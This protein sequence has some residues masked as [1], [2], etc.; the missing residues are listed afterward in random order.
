MLLGSA[1]DHMTLLRMLSGMS[2]GVETLTATPGRA[3]SDLPVV[4]LAPALQEVHT[5][6]RP[7]ARTSTY[8]LHRG[9]VRHCNTPC[10]RELQLRRG[11]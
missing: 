10:C 6:V 8:T 5:L 7:L 11:L 9:A 1:A 2:A 3:T 4:P